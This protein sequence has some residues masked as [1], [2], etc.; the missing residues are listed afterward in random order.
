MAKTRF[1]IQFEGFEEMIKKLSELEG[2]LKSVSEKALKESH[3]YVT[4]KLESAIQPS[5][6]PAKGKFSKGNT[7]K[8]LVRTNEVSWTGSVGTV[9]I[10]FDLHNDITSIFLMYGTPRMK[11]VK[12]LKNSIYGSKAKKE[13]KQIQKYIFNDAIIKKMEG[14]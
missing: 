13:I 7:S 6:L 9:K 8:N 5:K 11:P 14:H 2:D 1:G 12:G 4:P 3:A 10:G